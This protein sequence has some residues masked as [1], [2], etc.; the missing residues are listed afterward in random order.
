MAD[1]PRTR[2]YVLTTLF[3]DGQAAGAITEQDMRDF[4]VSVVFIGDAILAAQLGTGTT[5]GTT[6]LFGDSVFR[7]LTDANIAP[8]APFVITSP[9]ATPTVT[10]TA[11][12]QQQ[13]MTLSANTT[14]T[15]T[16]IPSGGALVLRVFQAASGGP[17]TLTHAVSGL[18]TLFADNN[19]A[20]V[21]TAT[22]G[23]FD[24]YL[25]RYD[26]TRTVYTRILTGAG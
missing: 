18:G 4:A 17:Y 21:M 7:A 24:D 8:V 1:T 6:V 3:E 9:G 5:D 26:G 23:K 14:A 15:I 11:A 2:S 16:G 10:W 20:P 22:A 13:T 19:T 12:R 25:Y